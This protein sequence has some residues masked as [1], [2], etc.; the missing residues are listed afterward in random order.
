M[1]ICVVD[2]ICAVL[3]RI[4]YLG[5]IAVADSYST[6]Q[7]PS[8]KGS[9]SAVFWQRVAARRTDI[10]QYSGGNTSLGARFEMWKVYWRNFIE[11]PLVGAGTNGF[12]ARWLV[13]G[14]PKVPEKFNN[15]HSTYFHI[16]GNYGLVGFGI[17][18]FF[19]W[20]LAVVGA[21]GQACPG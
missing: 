12:S 21:T 4:G 8:A 13:E 2:L 20:Q 1:L 16:L 18:L 9:S 7:A 15:P 6:V 5:F 3:G 11:H 14:Y 19:L 17:L 10:T